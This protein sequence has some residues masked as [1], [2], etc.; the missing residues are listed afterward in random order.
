MCI[1]L[2]EYRPINI[3]EN[4]IPRITINSPSYLAEISFL[5]VPRLIV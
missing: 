2:S 5:Q 3:P 1:I 4:P